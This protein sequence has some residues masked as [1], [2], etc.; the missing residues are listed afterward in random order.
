MH[1]DAAEGY[2]VEAAEEGGGRTRRYRR[3]AERCVRVAA[4]VVSAL[5]AMSLPVVVA[6]GGG[7]ATMMRP[8]PSPRVTFCGVGADAGAETA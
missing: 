8:A 2:V 6:D 7:S 4:G 5:A 3:D 1:Q